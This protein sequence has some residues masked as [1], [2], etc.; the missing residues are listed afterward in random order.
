MMLRRRAELRNVLALDLGEGRRTVL[1]LVKGDLLW[2]N[3]A[4]YT[5]LDFLVQESLLHCY[6]VQVGVNN[7][8]GTSVGLGLD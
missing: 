3:L 2:W 6:G 8:D 1:C 4:S 7:V 5:V